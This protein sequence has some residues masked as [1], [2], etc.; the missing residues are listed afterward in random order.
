MDTVTGLKMAK[1]MAKA[2]AAG[3]LHKNM[4]DAERIAAVK[5]L[6]DRGHIA[7]VA[8]GVNDPAVLD[9]VMAGARI[10]V[11]DSAHGHSKGVIE[12]VRRYKG[13]TDCQII[14]GNVVT[15][16]GAA[17]LRKAGA[18]AIKV[19][20][21]PGS[22]CTTRSVTGV[23]RPQFSALLEI[24]QT[25]THLPIIADGG[26]KTSGDIVKAFVAGASAVMV[27]SLLAGT[28]ESPG[29]LKV[30]G[31]KSYKEIRGMGSEAAMLAGSADRY[32]QD[33]E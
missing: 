24:S 19:G 1:A 32:N 30:I 7:A 17:A 8:V 4:P 9:L 16:K 21:G 20:V 27:G 5:E 23:G 6:A 28:L 11:V 12:A 25:I 33:S 29:G 14:A 10:L 15:A 26:I 18:D 22:I 13:E 2:G 31:D 3:V